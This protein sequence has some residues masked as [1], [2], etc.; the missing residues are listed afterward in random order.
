MNTIGTTSARRV[1]RYVLSE[2]PVTMRLADH[3]GGTPGRRP[4]CNVEI[5]DFVSSQKRM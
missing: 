1:S 5:Y 2:V 4:S 3:A